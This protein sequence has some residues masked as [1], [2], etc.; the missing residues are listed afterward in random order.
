MVNLLAGSLP[1][2]KFL[3]I[4]M[5]IGVYL[6]LVIHIAVII[7]TARLAERKGLSYWLFFWVS[8]LFSVIPLI[9]VCCYPWTKK[10]MKVEARKYIEKHDGTGKQNNNAD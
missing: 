5:A 2:D 6:V 9:F 10:A 3:L 1:E 7:A 8:V 4:A